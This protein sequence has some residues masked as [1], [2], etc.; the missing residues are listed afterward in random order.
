MFQWF[1]FG[2][3]SEGAQHTNSKEYMHPHVHCG[4]IYK[5]QHL[6][7]A[8]VSTSRWVDK[9]AVVHLHIGILLACKIERT[10]TLC[11]SMYGHGEHYVKWNK[12]VRER[13]VP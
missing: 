9:K 3:I 12:P 7:T 8:Q 11:D 6:E 4:I 5:S 1:Y 10:L 13:Q 2:N